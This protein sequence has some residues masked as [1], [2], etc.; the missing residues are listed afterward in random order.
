MD[1]NEKVAVITG[2]TSGI[3]AAVARNLREV[4]VRCVIGGRRED[5]LKALAADL[6]ETEA[7]AGDI[8]DPHMPERL[9]QAA[10]DA[11]GRCD[12]VV[13]NA[14]LMT[15][16]DIDSIDLD[17]VCDMV[18]VNV[19]AA[20]RMTYVALRHFKETGSGYIINTSSV[21]GTKTRANVGAY[22]G[23]K[24]AIEALSE[25]L[26]L[27]LAGTDIHIGCVEP[28]LAMTD[29]HRDFAVHPTVQ[30]GID[31][32]LQPEDVATCVRFMLEQPAHVNIARVLVVPKQQEV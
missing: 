30:Q 32:P 15:S 22:S 5:K 25:A 12:I 7:V 19:E 17:Y 14:G 10:K 31:K 3:G 21:L 16:G 23:T 2:A 9:I 13:N 24:Y 27:E 28:G 29:L 8:V 6:G 1:L 20:F 4:G 26:R 11:F 18:R